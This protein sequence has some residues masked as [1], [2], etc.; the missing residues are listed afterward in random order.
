[1]RKYNYNSM[2]IS[3]NIRI[4]KAT[5]IHQSQSFYFNRIFF[6]NKI[7]ILKHPVPVVNVATDKVSFW[8]TGLS[9]L[10]LVNEVNIC[11]DSI[12]E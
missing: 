7:N 4:F 9:L 10:L 12:V 5:K 1:M 6:I 8:H 3:I 11:G 2:I